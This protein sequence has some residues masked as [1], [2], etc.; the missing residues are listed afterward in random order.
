MKDDDE[1]IELFNALPKDLQHELI[2]AVEESDATSAEDLVSQIFVGE[3]PQCLSGNTKDCE[4][5]A[6]IEDITVGLC[7]D[8]ATSGVPSAE[9]P[10]Q[11]VAPANI[12]ESVRDAQ[13]RRTNSVSA[14]YP[15]G[16]ARKFQP[17]KSWK[18]KM[19]FRPVSGAIRGSE[20]TARCSH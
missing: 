1:F 17:M 11:R 20:R 12:G 19:P 10:S 4:G 7:K 15:H 16:T 13:G 6:E 8:C 9:G 3:C 5:E 2:K 18:M 14:G